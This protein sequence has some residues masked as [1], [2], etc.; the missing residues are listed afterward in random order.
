MQTLQNLYNPIPISKKNT[1]HSVLPHS[2]CAL[3]VAGLK[4]KF[5][6]W[7]CPPG[8]IQLRR[9]RAAS[10][11][12]GWAVSVQTHLTEPFCILTYLTPAGAATPLILYPQHPA[13]LFLRSQCTHSQA[14]LFRTSCSRDISLSGL[15][16]EM[17][18][19]PLS[20]HDTLSP[21][22]PSPP[23]P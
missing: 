9:E 8:L 21:L 16:P 5:L 18:A 7:V 2:P 23:S 6:F 13:S 22:T 4:R 11:A 17:P 10:N 15:S 1:L 20:F 12:S 14:A 3:D 19:R